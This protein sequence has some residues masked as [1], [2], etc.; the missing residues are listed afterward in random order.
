[1]VVDRHLVIGERAERKVFDALSKLPSPWRY[2]SSVDWRAFKN[3]TLRTGEADAIVFHPA[4]GL[5]VF[6]V[7]AGRVKIED[8]QWHYATRPMNKSPYRQARD[9]FYAIENKL[10]ACLGADVG[11]ELNITYAVWFP[12]IKWSGSLLLDVPDKSYIFDQESL[13]DPA[14]ALIQVL[15]KSKSSPEPVK[16]TPQQLQEVKKLLAPDIEI[17]IQLSTEISDINQNLI[18]ATKQQLYVLKALSTFSRLLVT[19]GAG[20]GKTILA[21]MLAKQHARQ[22][23][24]VLFT[25]YNRS[26]AQRLAFDLKDEPNITVLSFHELVLDCCRKAKI[27]PDFP[28]TYAEQAEW[29]REGCIAVLERTVFEPSNEYDTIIV[30]E[31]A[32]FSELWWLGLEQLLAEKS[33]WYCFYDINQSIYQNGSQWQKPFD[34][35]EFILTDNLRNTQPIGELAC[36]LGQF[37]LPDNFLIKEGIAPITT[38]AETFEQTAK[39]LRDLLKKLIHAEGV[40]PE[41]ITVLSPYLHTN[42]KSIWSKGLVDCAINS[43]ELGRPKAGH[44]RVGTIQGF[45]GLES[46]VVILVGIDETAAN[47][48]QL[49]YVGATRAKAALYILL[50]K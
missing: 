15:G 22:G 17:N 43:T 34:A 36:E 5:V 20:S 4:Y 24:R 47:R 16:W 13:F 27:D 6:E 49:L 33:S 41:Q 31:A 48:T 21:M 30:D 35:E 29:Y 40:L 37:A 7:K 14:K 50:K 46:D 12:D 2:F 18:T 3:D 42:P 44:I 32:D 8:G 28:K 11:K 19:G 26:L 39:H 38:A 10:K 9:N 23:K 45:K 1:M 25:C